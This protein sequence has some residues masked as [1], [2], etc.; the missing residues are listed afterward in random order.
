MLKVGVTGG[1]GSGKSAVSKRLAELGAYVFDAD[2]EAKKILDENETVQEQLIQEFGTDIQ[3]PN[4]T[5]NR[6][7][8]ARKGFS[9][10]EN[11]AILNAIIHPFVFDAIDEIYEKLKKT[12][13]HP[14][15]V[16]DAALIYESGLDQHLDYVITVTAQYGLRLKRAMSR[17]NL[18]REEV[19]KRMDL[20][21]PDN[22]KVQM[23][24]FIIDNNE[25]EEKLYK[26][27]D[28]VFNQLA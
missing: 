23:A 18:I 16:V 11:Q 2:R 20:Q 1:I 3:N 9:N 12:K 28:Q 26:Q 25:S 21:L 5:I 8:L 15:F 24:D 27:V 4:G 13:K 10:E 17:S 7:K 6:K 14:I 22:T 19:M